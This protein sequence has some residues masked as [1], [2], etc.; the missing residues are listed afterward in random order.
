[1][2]YKGYDLDL[3]TLQNDGS[4]LPDEFK[5]DDDVE[6]GVYK[7]TFD[8]DPKSL[9][10]IWVDDEVM[11]LCVIRRMIWPLRLVRLRSGWSISST[12]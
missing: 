6:N 8:A 5:I 10:T 9:R 7:R 12:Q 3:R 11:A 2:M 4:D 1:M